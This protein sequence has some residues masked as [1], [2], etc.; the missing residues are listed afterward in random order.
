MKKISLYICFV[1]GMVLLL[2]TRCGKNET[3]T[4]DFT[5][6]LDYFPT[7]TSTYIIYQVDSVL[8]SSFLTD[9]R[10][11]SSWQVKEVK[12]GTFIDN[13]GRKAVQIWR[14][15]RKGNNIEWEDIVP[16]VWYMVRDS[17][18]A[19]RME[20]ERRFVKMTFPIKESNSWDGTAYLNTDNT[21]LE[22]YDD[23]QFTFEDVVKPYSVNGLNFPETVTVN[24]TND[25]ENLVSKKLYKEI[26][27]KN[28]GSIYKEEWVLTNTNF[29]LPPTWPDRAGSG[30]IMTARALE[31]CLQ[32]CD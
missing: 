21:E 25:D 13:E 20:G 4:L 30:Y 3:E 2:M 28:I 5:Y 32:N 9:G 7:D 16:T 24:R 23:W 14:Y 15:S 29:D 27:A 31:Y 19:E 26:Y 6:G 17:Q 12:K 10:D 22:P 1:L 18:R 8:Y 11:T